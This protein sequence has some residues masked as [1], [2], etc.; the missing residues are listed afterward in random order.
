MRKIDWEK[1][2]VNI[3][4]FLATTFLSTLAIYFLLKIGNAESFSIF[5]NVFILYPILI[6]LT[7]SLF[8]RRKKSVAIGIFCGMLL[9]ILF[10][11]FLYLICKHGC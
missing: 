5:P 1:V 7:I 8:L 6:I 3:L 4:V 10:L 11:Y 9:N 2:I